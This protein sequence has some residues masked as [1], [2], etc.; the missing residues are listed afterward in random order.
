[1][2]FRSGRVGFSRFNVVGDAPSVIDDTALAILAE[3]AFVQ[4]E[5]GTPD[6]IE[7]GFITGEHLLDTQFTYEKNAFGDPPGS[8]LLFALR[9][10]TCKVPSEVK[11]AQRRIQELAAAA[12]NP[13]GFATK[14]QKREARELADR[15]LAEDLA[16]GK[17]RKS[18]SVA[19]LW[20]LSTHTLYCSAAGNKVVEQLGMKMRAAF[21]VNLEPLTSGACASRWMQAKG[22]S[23]SA[24]DLRPTA[25]TSAPS[26]TPEQARH[27]NDSHASEPHVSEKNTQVPPVPWAAASTEPRDFLGNEMLL[28][29]WWQCE[30][31]EGVI[32][33]IDPATQR[34][35]EL[36]VLLDRTL[37]MECAWGVSGKQSLRGSGPTRMREAGQALLA[38]KWPRK[39]GM[40]LAEGEAQFD[41]SLQADKLVVGSSTVPEVADAES[42]RQLLEARLLLVRRLAGMIDGLYDAFLS[43][44]IS[45]SW[46][47][48]RTAMRRWL[49]E[50]V[51]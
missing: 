29:L 18:K 21:E 33:T 40:I 4:Q 20:D 49:G 7:S 50:R 10:D 13:S 9:I 22:Q 24:D 31:A 16:Q 11:H 37:E 35:S 28:W 1:M 39:A 14:A 44:R 48:K 15:Q 25:F 47:A 41:L 2:S 45:P 5:I 43:Q 12:Q 46:P 17:Y 32:N 36:S 42:P 30:T 8:M 34:K 23:R 38:G 51:R 3:H 26:E 27:D 19:L 6:E